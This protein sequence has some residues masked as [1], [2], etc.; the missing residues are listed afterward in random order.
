MWSA[1]QWSFAPLKLSPPA[2]GCCELGGE[3]KPNRETVVARQVPA[4]LRLWRTLNQEK[5]SLFPNCWSTVSKT[6]KMQQRTT[7]DGAVYTGA[8]FQRALTG[9]AL[10]AGLDSDHRPND[11]TMGVSVGGEQILH[12]ERS[13]VWA[14]TQTKPVSKQSLQSALPGLSVC[15]YVMDTTKHTKIK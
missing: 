5:S 9:A 13:R 6:T 3:D 8:A 4:D 2:S 1:P 7:G 15:W 11:N 14:E 10:P 12:K